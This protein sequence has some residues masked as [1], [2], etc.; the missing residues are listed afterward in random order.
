MKVE[1]FK[2]KDGWRW[3]MIGTNGEILSTSEAYASKASAERTVKIVKD[4]L[5]KPEAPEWTG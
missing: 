4:A 5:A 1:L 3:R 2:G